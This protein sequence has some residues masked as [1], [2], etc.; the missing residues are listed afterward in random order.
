MPRCEKAAVTLRALVQMG[1]IGEE[2]GRGFQKKG[3]GPEKQIIA[4]FFEFFPVGVV[5]DP[6]YH[7]V[8]KMAV[9][10]G[11]DVIKT[12]LKRR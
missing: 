1:L 12:V 6:A 4:P 9:F 2:M 8:G 7:E 10:M 5:L 11:D 3:K